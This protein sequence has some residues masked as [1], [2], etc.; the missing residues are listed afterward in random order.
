MSVEL[1][2]CFDIL[3]ALAPVLTANDPAFFNGAKD[4]LR[5]IIN[6]VDHHLGF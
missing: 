4:D 3:P 2:T 1:D 6:A 5:I